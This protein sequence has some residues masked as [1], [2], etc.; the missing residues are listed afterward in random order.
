MIYQIFCVIIKIFIHRIIL[1]RYRSLFRTVP[2]VMDMWAIFAEG[3]LQLISH[4]ESFIQVGKI[5]LPRV[6]DE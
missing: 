3:D 5:R 1:V 6:F 2:L 4:R